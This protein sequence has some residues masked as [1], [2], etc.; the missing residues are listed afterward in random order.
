MPPP[1]LLE[2]AAPASVGALVLEHYRAAAPMPRHNGPRAEEAYQRARVVE[3]RAA[4][5][6][7]GEREA[8]IAL[9]RLLAARGR[10]LGAAT[11]LAK[12]ALMLGDDPQLGLELAGWLAG[13]GETSGSAAVLRERVA[14]LP[15]TEAARTLVKIAVLL[16]RAGEPAAAA[17][18]LDEAA[19]VDGVDAMA[20]ELFG[21]LA[22]WAPETVTPEGAAAA[23]LEAVRRRS[24]AGDDEAAFEDLLR[25]FETAPHHPPA[26]QAM[27][28]ALAARGLP[29]AGDEVLRMHGA[30]AGLSGEAARALCRR[31]MIAALKD[32][33]A[34]RAVGAMLDAGLE[35]DLEGDDAEKVDEVLSLAGLYEL[36]AARLEAR[37]ERQRGAARS[38]TYQALARLCAGPLASPERAI[39]A[40]IEA[41]ASD[42]T[43]AAAR[44]AL[45]DHAGAMRDPWPLVEAL[46]R[47]GTRAE[48]PGGDG[49]EG[50]PRVAALRELA[51]IAEE[52]TGD[53]SLAMWARGALAAEGHEGDLANAEKAGL[54]ARL[55][56]QDE[57]LAAARRAYEAADGPEARI[58]ALRRLAAE[59]QGRPA[60]AAEQIAVLAE[61]A[62]EAPDDRGVMIALERVSDRARLYGP[63]EEV[64]RSR[65]GGGEPRAEVARVRLALAAIARRRAAEGDPEA[66]ALDELFPLLADAPGHQGA[67]CA[68]LLLST[69][70]G[71]RPERALALVQIA[72][73]APGPLRAVLLSVAAEQH[74]SGEE[75]ADQARRTAAQ[76]CE[77]DPTCARALTTLSAVSPEVPDRIGAAAIERAMTTVLPRGIYC[78]RLARAFDD[79]GEPALA[80]A[81]TQRWLALR[82]GLTSAMTL[83]LRRASEARDATRIAEA[84]GWVLAQ[85]RPLG[86][87][88][89]P[90]GAA[91]LVLLQLD[92]GRARA[93]ARRTLDFLGPRVPILRAIL[94]DF[95]QRAGDPGLA[96]AVLERYLAAEGLGAFAGELLLELS[97]RR[98]EAGDYDGAARELARAA[99]TGGDPEAVIAHAGSLDASMR[100]AGAWLG[101][102][103]LVALA[104]A[105]ATALSAIGEAAA[106]DAA[107][108]WRELGSL[109]WDLAGDPSGAE[110]AFF[111]ACEIAAAR[112]GAASG[113]GVAR[114]A[115]DM[116]AFAGAHEAIDA[117][118]ARAA[119]TA[120]DA[121]ARRLRADLLIEAAALATEHGMPERAL[122]AAADAIESDPRRADAVPLVEKNAHVDGGIAV[123]DRTYDLLAGAALGCFG[124]RAAHYRGARQLE[125]RGALDL[126]ARHAA[127]CFE[128]LPSEG[129]S[130]VL[131]TR[132]TERAGD[133]TDAIHAIERVADA[134]DP[135]ER[136]M[137]LKRAAALAGGTEEGVRARFDLLLRALNARPD[138]ATVGDIARA[139]REL[140]AVGGAADGAADMVRIRFGRAVRASLPKLDGPE[141]AR[142]AV[143][144][145]RLAVEQGALDLAFAA[146]ERAMEVDGDID[147]FSSLGELVPELATLAEGARAWVEGV[148]AAADKPYSSAGAALLRL[149]GKTAAA[150]GDHAAEAALLVQ[151]VRRAPEDD[152]LVGE[153]DRA[154]AAAPD[155][156][157]RAKLDALVP[158]EERA[159]ALLRLADASERAGSEADAIASLERALASG[160]LTAEERDRA[161]LRLKRLLGQAG[162]EDE[163]LELLRAELRRASVPPAAR[164]RAA[165]DLVDLLVRRDDP[166]GAFEVLAALAEEGPPDTDLLADLGGLA[167]AAGHLDRYAAVLAAAAARAPGP[168]ER[169]GILR[170]LAPLLSELG[171]GDQATLRYEEIV[172]LDPADV[173]ALEIL[174]RA[175]NDRGDHEAIAAL[176]ARR[177]ALSP[178]GDHRRMLRLRRAAVLEQRTGR[179]EDAVRELS[180]LLAESPDDVSA[181]RFLADIHERRGASM[182]AAALLRRLGDLSSSSDEKAEY[183]L[184]A[185]AAFLAAGEVAEAEAALEAVAPIASREAVLELR[186]DLARARGD[187]RALSEALE[188]LSTSS[189]EPAE[190]RA[191]ILLEAARAASAAGDDAAALDRARRANKLAPQL[192]PAVLE[193]RRLE[194]RAGGAG[195]PREAQAAVEEL[196]R[197]EPALDPSQIELHAF[198]L[199]E[200]LD[201]IQ[202]GGAGMRVLTRRHAEVGPLPLVALGMAERMV[203]AKSFDTAL[204]L[205]EKALAGDL[206]GLR[207]RGRVALAAA[208]A[209]LAA[210]AFT[211]AA[212]LLDAAAAEPETQ[213]IA[214]RRQLEL[215][216]S[217]GDPG[218][219]RQALEELLRQSTGLDRARVLLQLGRLVRG[220]D[221]EAAAQHFAEAAPLSSADKTLTAQ[222]AEASERL[223]A[224]R[225]AAEPAPP[226]RGAD[227]VEAKP[228][229]P[230]PPLEPEAARPEAPPRTERSPS[231]RS[232]G[233]PDTPKPFE[234]PPQPST[235]PP[236]AAP[237]PASA[238]EPEAPAAAPRKEEPAAPPLA[239][240]EP[241]AAEPA[242]PPPALAETEE[243]RLL[244]ELAQGSFAAGE[245]LVA[246]YG[247]R[248]ADR[249]PD[250]LAVRRQQAQIR[251]GDT[252]ALRRVVEAAVL[253]G[254]AAYARAVENALHALDPDPGPPPPPLPAQR[255][256]PDLVAS[257]LF[258]PV[259]DSAVHEALALVLD[260]GLYRRDVGQYQLTGVA[261][262]QPGGGTVLGDVFGTVA[263]YLGQART[264]LFH[265]RPQ[266]GAA[267]PPP[268]PSFKIALLSPPAVVLT[269]DLRED[270]P[271][272]RYLLGA[273]LAGAM[274][275]HAI[276]NALGEEALRT[277]IDALHAAFGPIADL[278]RGNAAVA[279]LG[280]NLWQLVSPRADRRLREL[281]A[282]TSAITYEAAVSVT[283]QAMRRAGLFASGSLGTAV[284]Q[285]APDLSFQLDAYRGAP[286]GLAR[287]ASEHPEVADLL[288]LAIRT[289]L[290]EAR[291]APG[292]T[293]ERRR[294]EGP[295]PRSQRWDVK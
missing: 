288:K 152:G 42:A 115:R 254:N 220:E 245:Q 38:A 203:R 47:V 174:E 154:V 30:A 4:G 112:G 97:R 248:G 129:T 188:Q 55:A 63:L 196:T 1:E 109:R 280:Q 222:L 165:R 21:T 84:I 131:L 282:D 225:A 134:C 27:A 114:Y 137:W 214:Q 76:A 148:R 160:L 3:L 80:L 279:R 142:A 153:A 22:T 156:A 41:L 59:Y 66:H 224:E 208:E 219:A 234:A 87:F 171:E 32:G 58:K 178:A 180:A 130:Y 57:D 133:A 247:A 79:L 226:S 253:D 88:A 212:R 175:A 264:A 8:S 202:G 268:A 23:Y 169:L 144:M 167:R 291:W 286:D 71:L 275:E 204:P 96:I 93:L 78:D 69:R 276:V 106:A 201:V 170:E 185:G 292:A 215:A 39:E 241:S 155:P 7:A 271:E 190:R 277:L 182:E 164:A 17:E 86:D 206:Q 192:P 102:D 108:A 228:T 12:R 121:G 161:G 227:A 11:K 92:R 70:T 81:W 117:L 278:P 149:A 266:A 111:R 285:A 9:A 270:T 261:R 33:D 289:E 186:A 235:P 176:L 104:E 43:N 197:I 191:A 251:L 26:A 103:G 124:R 172:E 239:A 44:A 294:G 82:P 143:A 141:G 54:L 244:R 179:L 263:R 89:E 272:L 118:L 293:P 123:L 257:L 231:P 140:Y 189:R 37:G 40:W 163:A 122:A 217:I 19:G 94:L 258:R 24:A 284:A 135:A 125:R 25:A 127:A 46:V 14:G 290:A 120:A 150:L 198:L 6:A 159:I 64:L 168:A 183:G 29:G 259:A 233:V 35:G 74:A 283:R 132:L 50:S 242:A 209:A 250:V 273:A 281:C 274:P 73:P 157:I 5:D 195:T 287:A 147:E 56:R 255:L 265:L 199:A 68:A 211:L 113:G 67:A 126:A 2:R 243:E 187:A 52:R 100:E 210:K 260:T 13:L 230:S 162:R 194:Y 145:A 72:G 184:R 236:A 10:D 49:G 83:L 95:A 15:P 77:A 205:F 256:A 193:A 246:L 166:A 128:A 45:R 237:V 158:P 173:Q 28:Q 119:R 221:P 75:S 85:P 207:S 232:N 223:S 16:A 262:V 151:A 36:Y 110:E 136:P 107:A 200:E 98:T 229:P 116:S 249:T 18:A 105:R 51:A 61:L 20:I 99:E 146:L 31:R 48:G 218:V 252:A 62:K 238:S 240:P 91:L 60:E 181:M 90:I 177:I 269:G 34:A 138:A 139:I 267:Q 53:P 65:T 216:A 101:S 295:G 213:L